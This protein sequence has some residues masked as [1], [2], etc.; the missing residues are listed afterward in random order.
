MVTSI[1]NLF[2]KN[3]ILVELHELKVKKLKNLYIYP[4]NLTT[5]AGI[6]F[7]HL[8]IYVTFTLIQ[9]PTHDTYRYRWKLVLNNYI[10]HQRI[11]SD[12]VF[13]CKHHTLYDVLSE[14]MLVV[15]GHVEEENINRINVE[16]NVF[17]QIDLACKNKEEILKK[18]LAYI[19]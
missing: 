11:D 4:T 18:M 17:D 15:N 16:G 12:G 13:I 1:Q 10:K 9:E 8:S 5:F 2:R 6:A 3:K 7:F 14:F 19:R